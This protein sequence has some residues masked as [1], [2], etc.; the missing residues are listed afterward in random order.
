MEAYRFLTEYTHHILH[1]MRLY[2]YV[3][4]YNLELLCVRVR[5]CACV[6]SYP[7]IAAI[8]KVYAVLVK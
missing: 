2:L 1:M 8:E 3:Y 7:L 4:L 6:F 5:V